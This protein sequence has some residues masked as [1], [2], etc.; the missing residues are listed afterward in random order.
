V[1]YRCTSQSI[2]AAVVAIMNGGNAMSI[3]PLE[4]A[5]I[6]IVR[7]TRVLNVFNVRILT[8]IDVT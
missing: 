7:R 6:I 1:K 8:Q 4:R 2:A 3:V 5:R